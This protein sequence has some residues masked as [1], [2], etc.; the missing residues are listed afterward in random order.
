MKN[1]ARLLTLVA[2]FGCADLAVGATC[3]WTGGSGVSSDWNYLLNWS[4]GQT[5]QSG[6]DIVFPSGAA[7]LV[8]TNV[9][10]GRTFASITFT[11]SGYTIRGNSITL[12]G[13]IDSTAAGSVN[14][15]ELDINLGA[16]QFVDS[17]A[18]TATLYVN[19]NVDLSSYTLTMYG[20]GVVRI[21]GVISGSGGIKKSGFDSTH[22]LEGS[23]GNTYTGPT[24]VEHGTL[25]LDKASGN[26]I[27]GDS[28]TVGNGV[29]SADTAIVRNFGNYQIPTIPVAI[30]S[31]GWLDVD[32][33]ADTVGAITF[34]DGGHAGSSASGEL[35]LGGTV[36]V[37]ASANEAIFDGNV[38]LGSGTR[39]FDVGSGSV[40]N[41]LR[42]NAVLSGG[43]LSKTGGGRMRLA[44]ANTYV[45]TTTL[46]AGEVHVENAAAFGA[47]NSG[48]VV[49]GVGTIQLISTSI[50]DEQLTLSKSAAYGNA[51]TSSGASGWAG[52]VILEED[53]G[54]S[55]GGT[56]DF[57]GAI[58]GT[59][60]IVFT[61]YGDY[62]F[63]GSDFNTYQGDTVVED[64][65]LYLN[66]LAS[67]DRAISGPG[68]LYVGDGVSAANSIIVQWLG[69]YQVHSSVDIVVIKGGK[70][71]L[72][73]YYDTVGGL[74][75]TS[76]GIW[77][78]SGTIATVGN[79]SGANSTNGAVGIYGN[80]NLGAAT[81]T[82]DVANQTIM[83]I[84][85]GAISGTAGFQKTGNGELYLGSS[86]T[87]S[88]VATVMDGN[89]TVDHAYAMGD[90][91][92]GTVIQD[93]AV[94]RLGAHVV[95]EPLTLY[96][97]GSG[98]GVI[99][100]T[101][102]PSNS[103]AGPITLAS[104]VRISAGTH[105][106]DSTILS[107]A[108]DGTGGLTIS[109]DGSVTL[110]GSSNNTYSGDT[111]LNEGTLLLGKT[112]P[113][114]AIGAG[115]LTIGDGLGATGSAVVQELAS[116][117]IASI[118]VTVN[119]DGLLDLNN[120]TDGI[121]HSLTL[122]NGG[123]VLTGSG[124]LFLLGDSQIT[125]AATS[126]AISSISGNLNIGTGTCSIDVDNG[127]LNLYSTV[128][129]SA[130]ISVTGTAGP[131]GSMRLFAS[132]TFS[133]TLT[134]EDYMLLWVKHPWAMGTTTGGTVVNG[135]SYLGFNNDVHV[136][137]EPLTMNSGSSAALWTTSGTNSWGG[138]ITLSRDT[139]ASFY[140]NTAALELSG[141]M[142]GPGGLTKRGTGT[143][144]L[145]GG[146]NSYTGD[147]TVDDGVLE[148]AEINAIRYGTLT[149]GGNDGDA[150]T[151]IVR[152]TSN[153][154]IHS[155]VD[156]VINR[157][158]WID[159]NSYS[160]D[161]GH[162]TFNRG[163]ITTGSGTLLMYDNLTVIETTDT[164]WVAYITGYVD[165]NYSQMYTIDTDTATAFSLF[166]ETS[167]NGGITKTGGGQL[168]LSSSNSYEG[169]TDV[170]AGT[171]YV[172]NDYSLGT[173]NSGTTVSSN[174]T[175]FLRYQR[176]IENEAL[177]LDSTGYSGFGALASIY[178]SNT[179][180]GPVTLAGASR[181]STLQSSDYLVIDGP[182]DGSGD[183][184]LDGEGTVVFAGSDANTFAGDTYLNEGT[185]L[186]TKPIN[187][188]AI[189]NDLYIGDGTGGADADVV[190]L[191]NTSQ[192]PDSTRITIADSGLF[193]MND[194]NEFFGSL[195]GSGRVSMGSAILSPGHDG[196]SS[197]FSGLIEGSGELRKYGAGTF[198]LSGNNTYT[199]DTTIYQG[200]LLVNGS[201][202][203]SDVI[204]GSSGTL[205]GI[206][207]VGDIDSI[208]TVAPGASAG[209]L[210]SGS[211]ILQSG[212]IFDVELDGHLLVDYD[213]L[214]VNGSATINN[215]DLSVSW[216]FV[217]AK[218]DAFTII[219]NDGGDPVIG[220]FNGLA[221]GASV[222]AS[223]VAMQITYAGG[224][225]NDVVLAVTNVT[226]L[227]SLT[228]TSFGTNT[229]SV[230]L[231]WTGGVPFFVVQKRASLTTGSWQTVTAL[232]RNM[233]T[234]LPAT[235]PNTF[236]R[237]TGG[238]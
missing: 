41:D 22:W 57:S 153:G 124:T 132:N 6:D 204:V 52:D 63:T 115:S 206:G 188:I 215:A 91:S 221:E 59:G 179:W 194:I 134:L 189:V 116:F 99:I 214:D 29:S 86:N 144:V 167:G 209:Q 122:N 143:L 217:P 12:T 120:F 178:A 200:T 9:Y 43:A 140:T 219:D 118:P 7:R 155:D 227:E 60:G 28:L 27:G 229:A 34:S 174:A 170:N 106:Y 72:N 53:V 19:G 234:N 93:G 177:T 162:I 128:S 13:G 180:S 92:D 68:D 181:L 173:T 142:S 47:T 4:G 112:I 158:G 156:T 104:D 2:I 114:T 136:E 160:D 203:G 3:T 66:K 185:L 33:Y 38:Y 135:L 105:S 235:T 129:G 133:G 17:S 126:P 94:M 45:G 71:D 10:S 223:N 157:D 202:S 80:L 121:G 64:G 163:R 195:A 228:I 127:S 88:G 183:L 238:N 168:F 166:A 24:I 172:D 231:A 226:P 87:F 74:D 148:L 51:M 21:G 211:A 176:N 117:Q 232:T 212:S 224:T 18:A 108:I 201:Q 61:G 48:T 103:W 225:G 37:N 73:G 111:Y 15:L 100:H 182:I 32:D 76:A 218:G 77:T 123:N 81:R 30:E 165:L 58:S 5:P 107:G 96:G 145:S 152:F 25:M 40:A 75:L 186:L 169:A 20:L 55:T 207:S 125:C 184:T 70:V 83:G 220:T 82:I 49:T 110:S 138:P 205:G 147:T 101:T 192:I 97:N 149:V 44:A 190:R 199:G 196:S 14:T 39:T 16:S 78:G 237:I 139:A 79:I 233:E 164:N 191:E 62:Y 50:G 8:N 56:L 84:Y 150:A 31:D 198:E 137:A 210:G 119:A 102:A 208:G 69:G 65:T 90:T 159:F 42:I 113:R 131:V 213:Q 222:V 46:N 109:G 175:V 67:G 23:S 154:P 187:N 171:V 85:G 151:D 54:I 1:T 197:A 89:L 146:G 26:A 236:Y 161:L 11:G 193:D 141:T 130:D 95:E 216:G 36:T 35:R 230:D 98:S